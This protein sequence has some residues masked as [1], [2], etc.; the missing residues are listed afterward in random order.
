MTIIYDVGIDTRLS[1]E[2][3]DDWDNARIKEATL[4]AF[5]DLFNE[6]PPPNWIEVSIE[7][8][9]DS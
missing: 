4:Q 6:V 9:E 3:E 8:S 1:V 2:A 5:S 7:E